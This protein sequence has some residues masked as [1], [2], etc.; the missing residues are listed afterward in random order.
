MFRFFDKPHVKLPIICGFIALMCLSIGMQVYAADIP[1]KIAAYQHQKQVEKKK[2]EAAHT[3]QIIGDLSYGPD[4]CSIDVDGVK[5]IDDTKITNSAAKNIPEDFSEDDWKKL[6]KSIQF[7]KVGPESLTDNSHTLKDGDIVYVKAERYETLEKVLEKEYHCKFSVKKP[8]GS[9][10]IDGEKIAYYRVPVNG[11]NSKIITAQD[12]ESS[13]RDLL[14]A[15][16]KH[17]KELIIH[18]NGEGTV[19]TNQHFVLYCINNNDPTDVY[20]VCGYSGKYSA[21][22]PRDCMFCYSFGP[23]Y[24]DD[25]SPSDI[26]PYNEFDSP[27]RISI[28]NRTYEMQPNIISQIEQDATKQDGV[29]RDI[30]ATKVEQLQW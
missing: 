15:I 25:L 16:E 5:S 28:D 27:P 18:R 22:D 30:V 26:T 4:A 2:E 8:S 24:G 20:V 17:T 12:L 10:E 3:Y 21:D 9:M 1:G 19:I 23:I 14:Q 11:F 29:S 13:R 6:M 7:C